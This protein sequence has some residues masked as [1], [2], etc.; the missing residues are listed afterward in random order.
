MS[1]DTQTVADPE[2]D[3]IVVHDEPVD[4]VAAEE[5]AKEELVAEVA[6][7]LDKTDKTDE[8]PA[9]GET[10]PD[11]GESSPSEG[12]E[13]KPS[14]EDDELSEK[15]QTRAG[16]VGISEELAQTLHQSGQLEETLAAF[17][18]TLIDRF[19]QTENQPKA[20][21]DSKRR[22][23]LSRDK[24]SR[25]EPKD[26]ELEDV[27]ELDPEIHGEEH[28]QRDAYQTR[29]IDALEAQL[30]E[31]LQGTF[32]EKFD[33]MVDGL[34]HTDLFGKGASVSGDKRDNRDTLFKAYEGLCLASNADPKRCDPEWAERAVSAMFTKHVIKQAQKQTVD[35]L[36]NAEGKFLSP[37]KSKGAPPAKAQTEEESN[38]KLVSDVAA[39]LKKRGHQTSGF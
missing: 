35:R 21:E 23:S 6:K 10:K 28:I 5:K 31:V 39:L 36:R 18:R 17:D 1:T 34:G 37:S 25:K 4:T 32:V 33:A 13:E 16:E 3:A 26:Q 24:P 20:D 12:E 11:K 15:L 2:A 27:P 7:M 9:E 19:S 29:R 30:A 14:E 8:T 22:E 38:D